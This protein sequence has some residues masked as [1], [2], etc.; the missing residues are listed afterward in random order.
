MKKLAGILMTALVLFGGMFVIGAIFEKNSEDYV[1]RIDYS[2]VE[3]RIE[4]EV[5]LYPVYDSLNEQG[6]DYYLKLCAGFESYSESIFID[7]FDTEKEMKSAEDWL[8][9]NYR[10]IAYEQPDSFWTDPNSYVMEERISGGDYILTVKP[11]FTLTESDAAEKKEL[12]DVVVNG[13]VNEAKRKDSLFES[14]LYVY[15]TI[16]GKT[17]YDHS[18]AETKDSSLNGYSA[19]GCLVEGKTVCSG[20]TL[21]FTSIMQ[22]LD[23]VCGAEFDTM[24][25]SESINGHVWNYCKL[26]GEYY[27][28]DL[29][30]DD[31]SFDSDELRQYL[32]YT[33]DYFALTKNELR[34]TNLSV[35][36][37]TTSPD[38][39]AKAFNYY[40]YLDLYCEKYSFN[41]FRRIVKNQPQDSYAVIKFGSVAERLKAE[42]DLFKNQRLYEIFPD[43]DGVRY[44][45]SVSGL[46]LYIFFE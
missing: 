41:D 11:N 44:I 35:K 13:I 16:L 36:E 37:N 20:Y 28:F 26:D 30:W 43:L 19:Y 1:A 32:D 3:D 38:C 18:L 6:K 23:I 14:V 7:E 34:Q 33:H 21:A 27:Y 24:S 45:E 4:S 29:T 42:N 25:E 31:T 39:T 2:E 10:N 46:H 9:E 5:Y 17:D 8:D 15:D 22:K 12:Y 40:R